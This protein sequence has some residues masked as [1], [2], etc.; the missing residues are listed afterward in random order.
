MMTM[1]KHNGHHSGSVQDRRRIKENERRSNVVMLCAALLRRGKKC[2]GKIWWPF[3][4][5]ISHMMVQCYCDSGLQKV[6]RYVHFT[7]VDIQ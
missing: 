7:L 5:Q 1:T 6:F 4:Q 2:V 3:L